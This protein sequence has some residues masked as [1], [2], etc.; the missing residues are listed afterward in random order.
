MNHSYLYDFTLSVFFSE[1]PKLRLPFFLV[2]FIGSVFTVSDF[3][4]RNAFSRL[5]FAPFSMSTASILSSRFRY[6]ATSSSFFFHVFRNKLA[7][8]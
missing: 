2:G 4:R 1:Y 5:A 3:R 8:S 7:L 6:G